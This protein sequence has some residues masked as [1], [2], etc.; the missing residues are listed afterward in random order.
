[1]DG[2]IWGIKGV[3][4][5]RPVPKRLATIWFDH[6]SHH[7]DRRPYIVK[8]T[9][10]VES[11]RIFH[12]FSENLADLYA[13]ESNLSS[14]LAETSNIPFEDSWLAVVAKTKANHPRMAHE[15]GE[16][17]TTVVQERQKQ[18]RW[19]WNANGFFDWSLRDCRHGVT[20][21]LVFV[22]PFLWAIISSCDVLQR[23]WYRLYVSKVRF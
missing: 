11:K 12:H 14:T 3:W 9:S 1:M 17:W 19:R 7:I 22:W 15:Q 23:L 16:V 21:F 20:G 13:I 8:V 10:D 5:W 2:S 6:L 4:I 18:P